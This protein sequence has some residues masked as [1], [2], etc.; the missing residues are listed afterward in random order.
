MEKKA[1]QLQP[2]QPHKNKNDF[3]MAE[4]IHQPG[5]TSEED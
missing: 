3:D 1:Q 2:K 5:A 4:P